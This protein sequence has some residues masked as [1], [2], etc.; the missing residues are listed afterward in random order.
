ME[1]R[2]QV[3]DAIAA[4]MA[5]RATLGDAVVDAAVAALR[6]KLA[7][8]GEGAA[9][10]RKTVTVVMVDVQGSTDLAEH[11]S[12]E[13]WVALM[14]RLFQ[15]L[16]AEIYRYGGE[17]SQFR[18][19][20]L[21][22]F[23]GATR[24]HED[25]PQRAILASLAMQEA[26]K[27]HAGELTPGGG[28]DL[29]VR[30]GVNTGQVI[31][32]QIGDRRR[33]SEET[34]MGRAIAVAARLE[35]AAEA[36]T[37][38]VSESAYTLAR[39]DFEWVPIGPIR[40]KGIERPLQAYRPQRIRSG[41]AI[42]Q[43]LPGLA[44]P[45]VGR[46]AELQALQ[47]AV[48][49]LRAGV[50]GVVTVV[51]DAGLGKSRLV[52][53]LYQW[54]D[55]QM[56]ELDGE[57]SP[58]PGGS[59]QL[60]IRWVEG[61]C[62]SYA[63]GSAYWL[64]ADVVRV[65]LALPAHGALP[66]TTDDLDAWISE[67]YPEGPEHLQ[68]G[69]HRLL[70]QQLES[71]SREAKD[72]VWSS[73]GDTGADD[74]IDD[75]RTIPQ[76]IFEFVEGTSRRT[77]LLIVC[78]D[79]HWADPSSLILLEHLLPMTQIAPLLLI[80]VMRPHENPISDELI[81]V[82]ERYRHV[83]ITLEPLTTDES[84]TLV[85]RLL[86]VDA[87]PAALM[88]RVLELGEG[89][90]FYLEETL[91]ALMDSDA[92]AYDAESQR[93]RATRD[94]ADIAIPDTLQGVLQSRIDRLA[95]SVKQVLQLA[96]VIGR[97]FQF[98]VLEALVSPE[99][100]LEAHLEAL[101][102]AALIREQQRVVESAKSP[103]LSAAQRRT[104]IFKHYLT[105]QAAYGSLL[106]RERRRVH[107][108]V[109][110]ALK[111]LYTDNLWGN[112]DVLAYHWERTAE[113]SR[114]IPHLIR[115]A[116]SAVGR[117]AYGEATGYLHRALALARAA[118]LILPEA[119]ALTRLGS[120]ARHQ[121]EYLA[122]QQAFEAAL[123]IQQGFG[124]QRRV[125]WLLTDLANVARR[126]GAY[127]EAAAYLERVLEISR[128]VRNPRDQ[129]LALVNLGWLCR[130][131][132][133]GSPACGYDEDALRMSQAV[134][135]QN[136]EIQ[137]LHGLGAALSALG[138]YEAARDHLERALGR[139]RANED[140]R[141]EV[142]VLV[143]RAWIAANM[144]DA[145]EAA[146]DGAQAL[147]LAEEIRSR[148]RQAEAALVLGRSLAAEAHFDQAEAAYQRALMMRR[149]L[150]Q[151]HLAVEAQAGLAQVALARGHYVEALNL[152]GPVLEA[153]KR[154]PGLEG[155]RQ[156]FAV[157]LTCYDVLTAV[158]DPRAE[159][160][161][162]DV[163]ELLLARAEQIADVAARR[164]FLERVPAHRRVVELGAR[165]AP[166]GTDMDR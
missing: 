54:V 163:Y 53:E 45:L 147:E 110:E 35:A 90:P 146:T 92:I 60:A 69:L 23:F 17:V 40:A 42:V 7:A 120:I 106:E 148:P 70:R 118:K 13:A 47:Q 21:L 18:G 39:P 32:T 86:R 2:R 112:A 58:V 156:P 103:W 31:V 25:D 3:E 161:L 101:Q 16:Q 75:V 56:R 109:A 89:N 78:E 37:V 99:E 124:N 11:L 134:G 74:E 145:R 9:D 24:A 80:V 97:I 51:G 121:G 10:E 61:R 155:T 79:L 5:Q 34:A 153:L 33:H 55:R 41:A 49:R 64:W 26:I 82:A 1:E 127:A 143:E 65:M 154:R 125:A 98:G 113:P 27:T 12:V 68:R 152:L 93:W 116:S 135:F 76:A 105:Q 36:G 28:I 107:R 43:R 4:L 66:Q 132:G 129:I 29:R 150:G 122:A 48:R 96:S 130:E 44:S 77:P 119:D 126:R 165:A 102:D 87:L 164:R 50:G 133:M 166:H 91:R 20:G 95:P 115:A 14:D 138:D 83:G 73:D 94:V 137:A 159:A 22:A 59:G 6:E 117:S 162:T 160:V 72:E 144:G 114:A 84:A 157:F 38:L 142:D 151:E 136:G 62:V 128:L 67:A 88:A 57:D 46:E 15:V 71:S 100:P 52:A 111:K 140:P 108:E 19:D 141:G 131:R 81:A 139:Y 8:M 30:I 123:A 85:R 104:Y 158:H 149:E 63:S